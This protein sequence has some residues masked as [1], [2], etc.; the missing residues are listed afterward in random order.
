MK[1]TNSGTTA[2]LMQKVEQA[3]GEVVAIHHE[4][5]CKK[6]KVDHEFYVFIGNERLEKKASYAE[7][8][9]YL[10]EFLNDN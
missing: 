1:L 2:E 4:I 6:G 5:V 7:V 10:K 9:R 8:T 3:T